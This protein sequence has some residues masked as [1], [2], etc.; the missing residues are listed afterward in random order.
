[1]PQVFKWGLFI[2]VAAF[3]VLLFLLWVRRNR[4]RSHRVDRLST[5]VAR[6]AGDRGHTPS[7]AAQQPLDA[8]GH[9]CADIPI[10]YSVWFGDYPYARLLPLEATR[11][12]NP[13]A[14]VVV[15][16]DAASP[17]VRQR[18]DDLR[19]RF[20][21]VA[22]LEPS[23]DAE[24]PNARAQIN[25]IGSSKYIFSAHYMVPTHVRYLYYY[26]ALRMLGVARAFHIEHDVLLYGDVRDICVA[27]GADQHPGTASFRIP[28]PHHACRP[29]LRAGLFANQTV[30]M[31]SLHTAFVT[32]PYMLAL[33]RLL[34]GRCSLPLSFAL[35]P[36]LP[37]SVPASARR[38]PAQSTSHVGR[39]FT[40][41]LPQPIT[42]GRHL[43]PLRPY[44]PGMG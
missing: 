15:I 1:M 21:E 34:V 14:T 33:V 12:S 30:C 38:A 25:A 29:V 26:A 39:H 23:I 37:P 5:T 7:P 28:G 11:R 44:P 20:V 19:I 31:A 6:A 17:K 18:L 40:I 42:K 8:L 3:H 22:V 4:H 24:F 27:H 10:V 43:P 2:V 36:S 9:T 16:A 13:N 32:T 41:D 35:F